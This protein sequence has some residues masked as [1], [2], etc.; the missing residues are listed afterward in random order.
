MKVVATVNT[1]KGN[2]SETQ[3]LPHQMQLVMKPPF[4]RGLSSNG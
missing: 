4:R 3:L 1:S 2:V